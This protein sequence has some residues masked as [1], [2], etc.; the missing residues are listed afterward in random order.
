LGRHRQGA[1]TEAAAKARFAEFTAIWGTRYPA[2][3]RLWDNAWAEFVPFLAFDGE[4]R[5]HRSGAS[6]SVRPFGAGS[7]QSRHQAR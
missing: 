7:A 2:I 3:I 5:I 1:P 6:R 4:I